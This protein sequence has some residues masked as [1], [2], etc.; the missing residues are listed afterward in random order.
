MTFFMKKLLLPGFVVAFAVLTSLF[1]CQKDSLSSISD[2]LLTSSRGD[3]THPGGH[4]GHHHHGI[5]S[6]KLDSIKHHGHNPFDS[7]H[8]HHHDS[9]HVHHDSLHVHHD[10]LHVHHDSIPGGGG[11]HPGGNHPG[12][13]HGHHGHGG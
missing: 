4:H 5:D 8:V 3:S 11:H 13:G 6:T 12:G 10:S 9:L 2:E 7:L 1:S